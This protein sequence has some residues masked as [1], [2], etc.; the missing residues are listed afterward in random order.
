[1]NTELFP[2]SPNTWDSLAEVVLYTGDRERSLELYRKA[3]EVDPGFT[4]ATQQ[5]EKILNEGNE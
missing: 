1:L 5:I 3:L 2:N 4:N